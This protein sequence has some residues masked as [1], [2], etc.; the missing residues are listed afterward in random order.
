MLAQGANLRLRP[1][2]VWTTVASP[3]GRRHCSRLCPR[4]RF[5]EL[6]EA[7]ISDAGRRHVFDTSR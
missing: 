7:D 4:R 2:T 3:A 6:C 1:D 5:L